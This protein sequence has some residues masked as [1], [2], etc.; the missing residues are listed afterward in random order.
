M[1]TELV[2]FPIRSNLTRE[3]VIELYKRAE[4]TRRGNPALVHQSYLYD[5]QRN[6]GGGV[7][8]WKNIDA[9]KLGHDTRWCA[10]MAEMFGGEPTFE[11]FETPVVIDH[12]ARRE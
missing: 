11:Y 6:R 3:Q 5:G 8:L 2:T 4:P 7:Y 12:S 10:R 9:A 1:I